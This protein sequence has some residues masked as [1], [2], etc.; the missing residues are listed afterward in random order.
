MGI[1]LKTG[2]SPHTAYPWGDLCVNHGYGFKLFVFLH[3]T[4]L[5]AGL[6]LLLCDCRLTCSTAIENIWSFGQ[7]SM[8]LILSL[9][10][11]KIGDEREIVEFA[12]GGPGLGW[13][14]M[15]FLLTF[16]HHPWHPGIKNI[17]KPPRNAAWCAG[18]IPGQDGWALDRNRSELASVTQLLPAGFPLAEW[19]M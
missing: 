11:K 10:L 15:E 16:N 7:D 4:F 2:S 6:I 1:S 14:W 5:L 18:N 19:R 9:T 17:S 3:F 13:F 8:Q 12:S